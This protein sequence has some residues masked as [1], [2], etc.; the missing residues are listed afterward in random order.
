MLQ[1]FVACSVPPS[2]HS[3]W[4]LFTFIH[5]VGDN[6]GVWL[7]LA[8]LAGVVLQTKLAA[9]RWRIEKCVNEM[10]QGDC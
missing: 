3:I 9:A 6:Y 10:W 7:T 8:A 1:E 5:L 4:I 2:V